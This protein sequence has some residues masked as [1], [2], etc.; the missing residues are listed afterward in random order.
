MDTLIIGVTTFAADSLLS[1]LVP[2]SFYDSLH[3]FYEQLPG[4][5]L[6]SSYAAAGYTVSSL[7]MGTPFETGAL[8]STVGGAAANHATTGRYLYWPIVN[9]YPTARPFVGPLISAS[10]AMLGKFLYDVALSN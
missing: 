5:A 1:P 9:K 3:E 8:A 2:Q 7:I 10:G 4:I 6:G